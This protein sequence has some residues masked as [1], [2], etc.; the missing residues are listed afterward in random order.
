MNITCLC[1]LQCSEC[2][3]FFVCFLSAQW[4]NTVC[5]GIE[6]VKSVHPDSSVKAE[7]DSRRPVELKLVSSGKVEEDLCELCKVLTIE[8][9][10]VPHAEYYCKDCCQ[11]YC[12]HCQCRHLACSSTSSHTVVKLGT[13]PS[14]K[15]FPSE[16][17][18]SPQRSSHHQ[19]MA[20]CICDQCKL[21]RISDALTGLQLSYETTCKTLDTQKAEISKEIRS[22]TEWV[23]ESVNDR[24]DELIREIKQEVKTLHDKMDS[25]RDDQLQSQRAHRR[26]AKFA[27]ELMAKRCIND[28]R[29]HFRPHSETLVKLQEAGS[30]MLKHT[31]KEATCADA[32][33]DLG[34][35]Y[36]H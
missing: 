30:D 27:G 5:A 15:V 25:W 24:M 28:Q 32:S 10:V 17:Q 2:T 13:K 3:D 8:N 22:E 34:M 11:C 21:Q 14:K 4:L 1:L 26:S 9:F 29:V 7:E 31:V 20:S 16:K 33:I 36:Y 18:S 6:N 19:E 12:A 23:K 35:Y